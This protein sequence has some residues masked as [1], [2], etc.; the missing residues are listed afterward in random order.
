M[1]DNRSST[2]NRIFGAILAVGAI[3]LLI[4]LAL[5]SSPSS[6]ELPLAVAG[7]GEALRGAFSWAAFFVPLWLGASALMAFIPGFNPAAIFCLI[8]SWLPFIVVTAYARFAQDP[9]RWYPD[10]PALEAIGPTALGIAVC[11]LVVFCVLLIARVALA[12]PTGKSGE[13]DPP[14][15]RSAPA[16]E[17]LRLLG[18]PHLDV[19]EAESKADAIDSDPAL[20]PGPYTFTVPNLPPLPPPP[21]PRPRGQARAGGGC[22]RSPCSGRDLFASRRSRGR[23]AGP[24]PGSPAHSALFR[25]QLR[26]ARCPCPGAFAPGGQAARAGRFDRRARGDRRG[27]RR[28]P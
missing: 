24:Y 18:A 19:K 6:A 3:Y 26:A 13:L 17:P 12:L 5:A 20:P 4:S 9:A 7:P 2:A 25:P 22:G 15:Y 16:R 23:G 21:L 14:R 27:G 8:A 11:L 1:P 28:P 10:Y